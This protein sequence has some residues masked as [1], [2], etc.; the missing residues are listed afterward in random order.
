MTSMYRYTTEYRTK[1]KTKLHLINKIFLIYLKF[2]VMNPQ[3]RPVEIHFTTKVTET[4]TGL[5]MSLMI[6]KTQPI[7]A[8]IHVPTKV[9]SSTKVTVILSSMKTQPILARIRVPAKVA[10]T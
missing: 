1:Q 5:I 7:L 6:V 3:H 10:S 2:N 9:A 4:V 8:L